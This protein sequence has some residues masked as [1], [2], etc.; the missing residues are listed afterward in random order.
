M[1]TFG[2]RISLPLLLLASVGCGGSEKAIESPDPHAKKGQ[3]T[4]EATAGA[5]AE[6]ATEPAA[7][8]DL[9][10]VCAEAAA[11]DP[12]P[13]LAPVPPAVKPSGGVDSKAGRN[14]GKDK[15]SMAD[16][17]ALEKKS[18][19]VELLGHIDDIAPAK[20]G[21]A[22]DAM[23]E[24]AATATVT[25]MV[26][27]PSDSKAFEAFFLAE[28]LVTKYPQLMSSTGFSEKRGEAGAAA[29]NACFKSS[30]S[31]QECLTKALEFVNVPGT[32]PKVALQIGKTVRLNQ[33]AYVAVPF[34][35]AASL[36]DKSACA[37]KDL[38]MATMAGLGL[39]T[40]YANAV[41]A[42]DIAENACFAELQSQITKALEDGKGGYLRDNACAV[43][44]HKG[45][46][47]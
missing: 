15:Y 42:R 20:R 34:F 13:R 4:A 26:A 32:D 46:V 45:V 25:Q 37:D 24:R 35:R 9:N 2:L 31:G 36:T 14:K 11:L 21:K 39:P 10:T 43:L 44:R 12:A 5:T 47:Q 38:V 29:F 41:G 40:D 16:L 22:W 28:Q 8:G 7:S 23:L 18:Q 30:Y 3:A 19:H 27:S 1:S 17:K 33:F 6:A